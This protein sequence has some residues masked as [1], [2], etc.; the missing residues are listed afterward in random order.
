M[1]VS[2]EQLAAALMAKI[3]GNNLQRIDESSVTQGMTAPANRLDPMSFVRQTSPTGPSLQQVQMMEQLNKAA[4]QMYP[5]PSDPTSAPVPTVIASMPS[6]IGVTPTAPASQQI[7]LS[8]LT[9][10]D[11]QSIRSQL[12]KTNATLTKMAGMLGKVFATFTEKNNN[13]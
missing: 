2:E 9:R 10:E 6:P 4:E 11:V 5:L 1:A 7:D 8:V 13:S 12:E 3:T